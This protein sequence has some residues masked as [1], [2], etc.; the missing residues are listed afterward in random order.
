MST[1]SPVLYDVKH[2][3][4]HVTL[5]Q[6]KS[7]NALTVGMA[8]VLREAFLAAQDDEAVRVVLLTGKGRMFCAGGD[9]RAMH[10]AKH[11]GDFVLRLAHAAHDAIRVMARLEKPIVTAVQG[12]AAGAG[13]SLVLL[14]DVVVAAQ[15]A[16]FATA[17][18]TVG[19]TPDCGQSWLLPRAVG[20]SRALALTLNSPQLTASEAE[21]LG[22]V[23]QVVEEGA[24]LDQVRAIALR[25]ADG[26]SHAL[27]VA[28]GLIRSSFAAGFDEHLD[29]EAASIA[30]MAATQATG[31]LI[32]QFVRP[33][34]RH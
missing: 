13:L 9:L 14:S 30:A 11:R 19:L 8:E 24:H 18:T 16:V 33:S 31:E 26:P 17:Y 7:G 1:D 32:E 6:P 27:G 21:G 28:R 29:R 5:N 3:I 20:T 22:I 10:A 34:D 12:S 25:L 2:G 4:A 23:G 15:S